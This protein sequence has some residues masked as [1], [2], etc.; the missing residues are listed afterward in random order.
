MQQG[1]EDREQLERG[2]V[3]AVQA[4][5]YPGADVV[6]TATFAELGVDSLALVELA[7]DIEQ[8]WSVQMRP[9]DYDRLRT[10]ADAIELVE[11]RA[12]TRRT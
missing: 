11:E 1:T 5:A 8:R 6:P 4:L 2:V 10:V 9:A 3:A 12:P 7:L